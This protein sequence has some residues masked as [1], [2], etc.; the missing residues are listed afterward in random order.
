MKWYRITLSGSGEFKFALMV[1]VLWGG[2]VVVLR[3]LSG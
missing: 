3:N 1:L 2:I